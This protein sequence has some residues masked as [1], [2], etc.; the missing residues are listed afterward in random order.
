MAHMQIFNAGK[1][2]NHNKIN[3]NNQQAQKSAMPV[4]DGWTPPADP[5]SFRRE[6]VNG[7][8]QALNL[9]EGDRIFME[10]RTSAKNYANA[11]LYGTWT[12]SKGIV[13][14]EEPG[15]G[16]SGFLKRLSEE[17]IELPDN[18]RF[19]ISVDKY[20]GVAITGLGDETLA[21]R[22][23]EALSYDLG[24]INQLGVFVRSARVLEGV[25][26]AN[27]DAFSPEQ[28][29]LIKIQSDLM[30]YGVD[31]RDLGLSDGKISGLPQE[32]YDKIYGD[33]TEW[34][35]GMEPKEAEWENWN[36]NRIR[37]DAVYFL[38][39]GTSHVNTPN[40][41]MTFDNG[42]LAVDGGSGFNQNNVDGFDVTI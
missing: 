32:L 19:D 16:T 9:T 6:S 33:R 42:R 41:S 2:I 1:S 21:R 18:V 35:S 23:E 8:N 38:Q 25:H 7:H 11:F 39:T 34:L 30:S 3:A 40:I 27:A 36:I 4:P 22:I 12:D 26:I 24:Q 20:G 28:S 15:I 10:L 29:R 37:D 17:G 13:R 5:L 14:G 31:L